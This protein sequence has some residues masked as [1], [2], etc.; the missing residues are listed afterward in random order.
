MSK[1]TIEVLLVIFKIHIRILKDFIV[2]EL[3][4]ENAQIF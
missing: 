3:H 4:T 2:N 1:V